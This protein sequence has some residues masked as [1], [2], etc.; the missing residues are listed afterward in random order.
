M[1]LAGVLSLYSLSDINE[2][3]F[4]F[5]EDYLLDE[6]EQKEVLAQS[7]ESNYLH[8]MRR[9]NYMCTSYR[10]IVVS[11][12][13]FVVIFFV[14][15]VSMIANNN[16]SN[17]TENSLAIIEEKLVIIEGITTSMTQIDEGAQE[18]LLS[19]KDEVA[20]L[21]SRIIEVEQNRNDNKDKLDYIIEKLDRIMQLE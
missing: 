8:N 11:I 6:E 10:C 14:S 4:P 15:S 9:N 12:A 2:V 19:I 3:S 1:V 20:A 18:V 21:S 13:L 5:P 17:N 16:K 7:I